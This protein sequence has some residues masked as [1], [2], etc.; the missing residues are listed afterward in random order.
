MSLSFLNSTGLENPLTQKVNP[1]ARWEADLQNQ[2][3]EGFEKR[4]AW[5]EEN[6]PVESNAITHNEDG[7]RLYDYTNERETGDEHNLYWNNHT[8]QLTRAELEE[9]FNS[10]GNGQLRE[11]FGDFENYMAYMD[12]RQDLIASGEL[13][14]DWWD[15]GRPLVNDETG[16]MGDRELEQSIINQGVEYGQEG[17]DSQAQIQEALYQKYTGAEGNVW[18]NSDGDTFRWNGTSFVKTGKVDDHNYGAMVP[19]IMLGA[20]LTAGFGPML[21]SALTSALGPAAAKAASSAILNIAKQYMTTGELS[22]EDALMSAALSYGGSELADALGGSGVVGEIGSQINKFGESL[23]EGGGDVLSAALQAGGMSLVTQLVKGGEIDW[24]NAALAAAMAGGTTYLQSFL[25]DIGKSD[26]ID[27]LSEWDEFDEWQEEAM[28]ADIKDPFLNPNYETVGDGLVMNIATGE[29]FSQGGVDSKSH[30]LFSDLDKDGDGQLSGNDLEFI[31]VDHDYV[32][33]SYT[34]PNRYNELPENAGGIGRQ[35]YVDENG[36]VHSGPSIV[37]DGEGGYY[38]K[39]DGTK[40]KSLTGKYDEKEGLYLFEDDEGNI[41]S[42]ADKSGNIV[43]NYDTET[44]TWLDAD[45]EFNEDYHNFLDGKY[46]GSGD[47]SSVENPF[48]ISKEQYDAFTDKELFD[49]MWRQRGADGFLRLTDGDMEALVA[50]FGSGAELEKYL[51]ESGVGVHYSSETGWVLEAGV[52]TSDG[53]YGMNHDGG[54][55]ADIEGNPSGISTSYTN[56][57]GTVS[58]PT[59]ENPFNKEQETKDT[60]STADGQD[61]DSDATGV[62]NKDDA[63]GTGGGGVSADPGGDGTS[64][65]TGGDSTAGGDKD[66][67]GLPTGGNP[68]GLPDFSTMTPAE[69]AAWL[70][71]NG[72]G[73]SGG[74]PP[75]TP[76]DGTQDGDGATTGGGA[77]ETPNTDNG[78]GGG[79]NDT[80]VNGGGGDGTKDDA[81]TGGGDG[82]GGGDGT[83]TGGTGSGSGGGNSGDGTGGG[84]GTSG[85]VGDGSGAD[86]GTG[87]GSGGTAGGGTG[88][89]AGGTG[90]GEGGG[91]EGGG[92]EGGGGLGNGQGMLSGNNSNDRPVW[93][94]LFPMHQFK[95]RDKARAQVKAR[96]FDDL[97]KDY[98]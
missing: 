94:P 6:G 20:V 88:G 43:A 8:Q 27:D 77:D 73:A 83:A 10:E 78:T 48:D 41:V 17:Y 1:A 95:P 38:N 87:G 7:E 19:S 15:T 29:V 98:V 69:I 52:D 66:S 91:G 44:K 72:G 59:T 96:L 9:K 11:A 5:L 89:T 49:D 85:G 50:K 62:D 28:K 14:A 97:F 34:P 75:T 32:D 30:G 3:A 53:I 13:K 39:V 57:D 54:Y 61:H 86:G 51:Q 42:V 45:G 55:I 46:T 37:P 2:L 93:G 60:E 18:N 90:G 22:V 68:T 36:N 81:G 76:S 26:Q 63:T 31:D 74:V 82:S 12:E 65:P 40:L 71:S 23:F 25:A 64:G 4:D 56:P 33:P 84:D 58:N 79:G 24:K 16:N 67:T 80:T 47:I 21:T 70:A 92:G 35:Y